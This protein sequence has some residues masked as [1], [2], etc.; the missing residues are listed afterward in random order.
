[1]TGSEMS[2][3]QRFSVPE[4]NCDV[5]KVSKGSSK[6]AERW[7]FQQENFCE[8]DFYLLV[9]DFTRLDVPPR[10]TLKGPWKEVEKALS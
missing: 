9:L 6:R 5:P 7:P 1:M 3:F 2:P 8:D 10:S 4:D